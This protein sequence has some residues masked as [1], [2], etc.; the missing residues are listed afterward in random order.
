[1]TKIKDR[2][3]YLVITEDY[4]LGKD[5]LSIAKA[6]IAGGIDILQMREKDKAP[7]ELRRIGGELAKLCKRSKTLFIVNDDPSLAKNINADGVHIGQSDLS[8]CSINEIRGIIG[9]NGLI[10]LSTHSL[11]QFRQ[12]NESGVDYISFGPIFPTK[13][14]DYF[15]GTSE[16]ENVLRIAL[17]PVVFI[18]GI[19]ILN[20]DGLLRK[21]AR[22]IA[23]ISDI[24]QA[25]DITL[26]TKIFKSKLINYSREV[27]RN[28][29]KDKWENS[30]HR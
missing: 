24:V 19:N 22:N 1:M 11:G 12:A 6:A 26:K 30:S 4:S 10:G 5:I 21:G 2:S 15:I 27:E 25:E 7:E 18:G 13:T 8:A 20:L 23:L 28:D 16:V 9:N 17:K 14:K 29:Y 3:L